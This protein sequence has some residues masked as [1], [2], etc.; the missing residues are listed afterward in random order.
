L[1]HLSKGGKGARTQEPQETTIEAK[2]LPDQLR[3]GKY[4]M[5]VGHIGQDLGG[6]PVGEGGYP[7]GMARRAK[8][9]TVARVRQQHF[10]ATIRVFTA[11]AGE[12]VVQ[13]AAIQ[14]SIR[15]LADHR[16]PKAVLIGKAFLVNSLEFIEVIFDQPIKRGGFGIARLIMF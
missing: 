12:S 6:Q 9:P 8:V 3:N 16:P 4:I 10:M 15:H 1:H 13:V 5:A 14:E 2:V 11:D 7:L